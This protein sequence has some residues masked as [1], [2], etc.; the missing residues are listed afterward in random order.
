MSDVEESLVARVGR[1]VGW[2]L[3]TFEDSLTAD[4][5][6]NVARQVLS[7][8][9][10]YGSGRLNKANPAFSVRTEC[11]NCAGELEWQTVADVSHWWHKDTYSIDCDEADITTTNQEGAWWQE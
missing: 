11:S 10:I 2:A 5:Q 7:E 4:G 6:E 3:D 9:G 8:L 1:S